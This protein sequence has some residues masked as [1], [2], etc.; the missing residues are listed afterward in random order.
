MGNQIPR[1][2]IAKAFLLTSAT[3]RYN[4]CSECGRRLKY[5][6]GA[7]IG[8][9]GE[10]FTTCRSCGY[11]NP[12]LWEKVAESLAD[13]GYD[14]SSIEGI[15]DM[16]QCMGDG[17]ELQVSRDFSKVFCST[18]GREW[19]RYEF[20]DIMQG[21]LS[22]HLAGAIPLESDNSKMA[23]KLMETLQVNNIDSGT[24]YLVIDVVEKGSAQDTSTAKMFA[25]AFS[26][27]FKGTPDEPSQYFVVYADGVAHYVV[28]GER[29]TAEEVTFDEL[30][31]DPATDI[32][33]PFNVRPLSK[34]LTSVVIALLARFRMM[35]IANSKPYSPEL[36]G[37][38]AR[39]AQNAQEESVSG[40]GNIPIAEQLTKLAQLRD[41]GIL[42][43]EEFTTAKQRLIDKL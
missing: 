36:F 26:D 17:T 34:N 7:W 25:K 32:E 28:D 4:R 11:E 6:P 8:S 19:D 21:P 33:I 15:L 42:T 12:S 14:I 16:P 22:P 1:L 41:Q 43:E 27:G 20:E 3:F 10:R 23:R 29:V 2:E 24:P 30:F 5:K 18:C 37:S 39:D 31:Q 9:T 35:H 38:A 13:K 40:N